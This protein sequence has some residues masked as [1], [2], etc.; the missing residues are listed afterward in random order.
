MVG[1]QG[2]G[3]CPWVGWVR[4]EIP[5]EERDQS[6]APRDVEDQSPWSALSRV[7]LRATEKGCALGFSQLQSWTISHPHP[8]M[9]IT[10]GALWCPVPR[11]LRLPLPPLSSLHPP[12]IA[13][14]PPTP[15]PWDS[16]RPPRRG[17]PTTLN[18]TKESRVAVQA[19]TRRDRHRE[20]P[21]LISLL[22]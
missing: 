21:V 5:L 17:Q 20:E 4:A 16:P 19:S 22:T 12:S 7:P 8:S 13:G 3:A 1:I 14:T 10:S 2:G 9:L 11:A 18:T 6:Q 15:H